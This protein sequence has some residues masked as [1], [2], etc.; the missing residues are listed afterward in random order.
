MHPI[1]AVR[2]KL[3]VVGSGWYPVLDDIS[4]NNSS[5]FV[6]SLLSKIIITLIVYYKRRYDKVVYNKYSQCRNK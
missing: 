6:N 4:K 5:N 3:K 1:I 2:I